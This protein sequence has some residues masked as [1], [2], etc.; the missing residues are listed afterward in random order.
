VEVALERRV[1]PV[2]VVEAIDA[3]A[4]TVSEPVIDSLP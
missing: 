1:A 4:D 3:D 2:S